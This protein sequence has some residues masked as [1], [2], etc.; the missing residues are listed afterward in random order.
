MEREAN[1][2]DSVPRGGINSPRHMEGAGPSLDEGRQSPPKSPV[3]EEKFQIHREINP[4]PGARDPIPPIRGEISPSPGSATGQNPAPDREMPSP[5][6]RPVRAAAEAAKATITQ[7][8]VD[9]F[10]RRKKT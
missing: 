3:R 4:S 5:T 2:A 10:H 1:A 8:I 9:P 6:G 7:M